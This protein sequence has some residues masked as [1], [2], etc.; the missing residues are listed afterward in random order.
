VIDDGC[1]NHSRC[2]G[3]AQRIGCKLR[4]TQSTPARTAVE[5]VV[6]VGICSSLAVVFPIA[7]AS[8][9]VTEAIVLSTRAT[10]T[11]TAGTE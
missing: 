7:L 5:A 9:F 6:A 10:P 2:T 1:F 4:C 3:F 8:V 11:M